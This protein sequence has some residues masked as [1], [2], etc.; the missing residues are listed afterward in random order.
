[1]PASN[2]MEPCGTPQP[3]LHRSHA[4]NDRSRTMTAD[5]LPTI[6]FVTPC[7]NEQA[8]LAHTLTRLAA[9]LDTLI[10]AKQVAPQSYV[11]F[12]DDGSRDA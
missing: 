9:D 4:A 1:M 7:Y 8:V 6:V 2:G 11:L 10:E 12:V 3:R 5:K